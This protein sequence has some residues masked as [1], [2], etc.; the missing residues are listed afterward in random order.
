LAR[1]DKFYR[2]GK[3][4][5]WI[6]FDRFL[7]LVKSGEPFTTTDYMLETP[8][9]AQFGAVERG[10]DPAETRF[11]RNQAIVEPVATGDGGC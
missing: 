2:N 3:W 7:E 10:F 6:D 9:W 5:T 1:K 8:D 4:W 11:R